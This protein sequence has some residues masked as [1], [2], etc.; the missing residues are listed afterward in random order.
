MLNSWTQII[1]LGRSGVGQGCVEGGKKG[2]K[3]NIYNTDTNKK[4]KEKS[5]LPSTSEFALF[6][7]I[8]TTLLFSEHS[9]SIP[10]VY[11]M[12]IVTSTY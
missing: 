6:T 8:D 10:I 2:E 7:W 5:T 9:K 1:V 11:M 4:K 12:Y 3:G